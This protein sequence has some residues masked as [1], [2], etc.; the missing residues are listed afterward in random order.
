MMLNGQ[1]F[2]LLNR[3]KSSN[4]FPASLLT[5]DDRA[6]GFRYDPASQVTTILHQLTACP[7]RA[8]SA[9]FSGESLSYSPPNPASAPSHNLNSSPT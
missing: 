3:S 4:S 6:E 5:Y 7:V 1:S 9:G 2:R 8:D